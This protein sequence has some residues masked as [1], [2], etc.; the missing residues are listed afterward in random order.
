MVIASP[1]L[2]QPSTYFSQTHSSKVFFF[3]ML[4]CFCFN[5][6]KCKRFFFLY[7]KKKIRW[8]SFSLG[9]HF[10]FFSWK[11]GLIWQI[12]EGDGNRICYHKLC[13]A[14]RGISKLNFL[15]TPDWIKKNIQKLDIF[16][17]RDTWR[18]HGTGTLEQ[19]TVSDEHLHVYQC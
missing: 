8:Y 5:H 6:R 3:T 13:S 9:S 14:R 16:L 12:C 2:I 17:L 7:Q 10:V 15:L 1:E 4:C 11:P 18:V 19:F